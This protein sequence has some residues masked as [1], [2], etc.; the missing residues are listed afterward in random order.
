MS[1]KVAH[2]HNYKV[3]QNK[4]AQALQGGKKLQSGA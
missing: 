4:V 3:A 2:L 1:Y